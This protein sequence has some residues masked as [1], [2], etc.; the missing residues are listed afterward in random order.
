MRTSDFD[1]QLPAELIAQHPASRRDGSRLLVVHRETGELEHR[2]FS[3][4]PGYLAPGGLL[5]LNNTKVFPARFTGALEGGAEFEVL[6]VRPLEA[7]L[8]VA[9][10]RPGRRMKT[11]RWVEFGGGELLMTVEDFGEEK[12][13][14]IVRLEAPR[15]GDINEL[16]E[17]WGRV[18]LPPY[19]ERT[20]TAEDRERYQTVYASSRGAVAAPT[21]GLHFTA[22]LLD[23][24]TARGTE[25]VELTLHVG[26]GTFR[27]VSVE[28]VAKHRMGRE[29]YRIEP[30]V[31]EKIV[32][33]RK[34]GSKLTAVGTT[35]VRTLESCADRGGLEGFTELFITPG[36]EFRVV[37]RLLTNFHL[38]RSTLL[39]LVSA[40]AGRDLILEAYREAVEREYRFYSYGDAMLIL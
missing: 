14:R 28:D 23:K 5:A 7:E 25:L 10:V 32:R 4:L 37:D 36:F 35:S 12:G 20:D 19:I 6:L 39:M 9:L 8:W 30:D 33:A 27:P 38:P 26:P 22:A 40:F 2:G 17:R 3:D 24:L 34:A 13:E 1:Y 29:W 18:P 15:G 11:G 31:W 21:A 16:I